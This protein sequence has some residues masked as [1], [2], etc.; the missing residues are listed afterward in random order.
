MSPPYLLARQSL[1]RC[2]PLR[3][4]SYIPRVRRTDPALRVM[5]DFLHDP[6]LTVPEHVSVEHAVDQMFRLGVRAALVVR[7]RHVVGLLTATQAA[8]HVRHASS[9]AH[10]ARI[11]EA[12]TPTDD[13]PAIDWDTLGDA[14]VAD[15]IEIFDG[16][17]VE[18][19]VVIESHSATLST[20]RGLVHRERLRRAL[21]SPWSLRTGL[22]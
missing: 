11:A 2:A 13:A 1:A 9:G 6:P 14:L 4:R 3:M 22:G 10:C 19:L 5:T 7:D 21:S 15:L 18:H 17:G 12:M 8:R 20:V 16:T